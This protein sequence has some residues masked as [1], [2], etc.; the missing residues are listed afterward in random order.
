MGIRATFSI[1]LRHLGEEQSA[2][3]E[4][5]ERA[6]F[7]HLLQAAR[8]TRGE[9]CHYNSTLL[10]KILGAL[11]HS[12]IDISKHIGARPVLGLVKQRQRD[13]AP[14]VKE[15]PCWWLVGLPVKA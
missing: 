1:T 2:G 6:V 10:P 11:L 15:L 7:E 9:R 5:Y 4:C 13:I 8:Q 12:H 3:A 14:V